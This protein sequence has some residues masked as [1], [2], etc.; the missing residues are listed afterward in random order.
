M[1]GLLRVNYFV[2][3]PTRQAIAYAAATV[4]PKTPGEAII[5]VEGVQSQYLWLNGAKAIAPKPQVPKDQYLWLEKHPWRHHKGGTSGVRATY[6]VTLKPGPNQILIKANNR[7]STEWEFRVR[8]L[9]IDGSP[10]E[11]QQ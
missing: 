1:E 5:W 11:V 3:P 4:T 9:G 10:L 6:K 8:V 7:G 2:T